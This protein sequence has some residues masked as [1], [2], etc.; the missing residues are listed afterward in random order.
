MRPLIGNADS[1]KF[2]LLNGDIDHLMPKLSFIKSAHQCQTINI[3]KCS[4]HYSYEIRRLSSVIDVMRGGLH[5][6]SYFY[7]C[8][9]TPSSTYMANLIRLDTTAKRNLTFD[10][11]HSEMIVDHLLLSHKNL[12]DLFDL[13]HDTNEILRKVN[14]IHKTFED[15]NSLSNL[16]NKSNLID[17]N[18]KMCQEKMK[19]K[20]F[21]NLGCDTIRYLEDRFKKWYEKA[22][23]KFED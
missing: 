11:K 6:K 14:E 9:H 7:D 15:I 8:Y 1:A 12:Q 19:D 16:V 4:G 3:Y 23:W 2:I 22:Q 20:N 13:T 10:I 5:R 21:I 18:L 17:I